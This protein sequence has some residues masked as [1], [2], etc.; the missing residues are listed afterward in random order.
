MA[1]MLSDS[2]SPVLG[3]EALGGVG[4]ERAPPWKEAQGPAPLRAWPHQAQPTLGEDHKARAWDAV[5]LR[6]LLVLWPPTCFYK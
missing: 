4:K 5:L 1:G 3:G 2:F 6:G